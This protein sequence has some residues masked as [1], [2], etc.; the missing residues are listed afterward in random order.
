[1]SR[2]SGCPFSIADYSVKIMNTVTEAFVRVKGLTSM[3]VDVDAETEDGKTSDSF[4]SENFV[5]S[6]S[7]SGELSGRPIVD[8]TTGTRDAGQNLMHKAAMND[9]G[10]D[11]DQTL[12]IA[13]AVGRAVQ[14]D[15]VIT[16]ES[17]SADE[18]G[19]EISWSWEGVGKPEEVTY[20]QATGVSYTDTAGSAITSLSVVVNETAECV[21]AI[22]PADASNQR[23]AYSIEDETIAEVYSVDDL[24]ISIRGISAGTTTLTVKTMNNALTAELTITVTAE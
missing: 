24:N 15:C 14:Y 20:V 19:E 11:N 2:A 8:R 17:K 21:V 18:D 6:R 1:M 13:D 16:A 3:S 5:K 12:L 7:V 23:Y 10:C 9:G 22:T 4:W